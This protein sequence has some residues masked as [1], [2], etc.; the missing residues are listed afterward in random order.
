MAS[1]TREAPRV[2]V[3]GASGFTGRY[4]T[5]ALALAGY[6]PI[7]AREI[8]PGFDLT[9]GSSLDRSVAAMEFDYVI[10]LAAISYVGHDD[11]AAFYQVNTVGTVRLLE[12]IARHRTSVRKVI[13]A[14]SAN[15]YGNCQNLP[16]D[17]T[18]P[19][20]PVNHYAASKL[21]MEHLVRRWFD[22]LPIVITRPFNYTGRGQAANFLVPKIVLSFKQRAPRLELG[23]LDIVRDFSDVRTVAQAYV[24]LLTAPLCS[25]V[26]NVCS[27]EGRALRWITEECARQTGHQLEVAVNPAFVRANEVKSLIGSPDKLHASIGA[28]PTYDFAETLAWMLDEP[29]VGGQV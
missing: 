8:G 18:A 24:Q 21:A 20:E 29:R 4:V 22:R 5:A 12:A 3:T 19:P 2:L 15:V 16:I 7:D 10:H 27:G 1:R 23:N 13:V 11:P 28:L 9:D 26:V 17:E 25:D 14:S 6:D